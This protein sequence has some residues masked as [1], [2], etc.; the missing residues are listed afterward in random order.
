M[1]QKEP[2]LRSPTLLLG[3]RVGLP[4]ARTPRS[5]YDDALSEQAAPGLTPTEACLSLRASDRY[6][7]GV[8]GLFLRAVREA[9]G[10]DRKEPRA[11]WSWL[12]GESTDTELR[13]ALRLHLARPRPPELR[14]MG[15]AGYVV[16]EV[17]CVELGFLGRGSTSTQ[18]PV[19]R[20][21]PPAFHPYGGRAAFPGVYGPVGSDS[22]V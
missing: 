2:R 19:Q 20:S 22:C 21:G 11:L 5:R 10:L 1:A 17:S 12:T 13:A 4:R 6:A 8:D 9:F 16:D 7:A 15:T 14:S 3:V 18:R